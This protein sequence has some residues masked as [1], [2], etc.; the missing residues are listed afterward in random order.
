METIHKL[1]I[2]HVGEAGWEI[3]KFAKWS[4]SPTSISHF[5][6]EDNGKIKTAEKIQPGFLERKGPGRE[7]FQERRDP[8]Q[9]H[10]E[11]GVFRVSARSDFITST[12]HWHLHIIPPPSQWDLCLL[13]P[14][15]HPHLKNIYI[16]QGEAQTFCYIS[17]TGFRSQSSN[18]WRRWRWY[19]TTQR[20]GT[21]GNH[22]YWTGLG[23]LLSGWGAYGLCVCWEKVKKY[24]VTNRQTAREGYG[25][26][27][28]SVLPYIPSPSGS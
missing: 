24:W 27:S 10:R 22:S 8:S 23:Y 16:L 7:L 12:G 1:L 9:A 14:L 21:W 13:L 15:S 20:S 6:K 19:G 18:I 3:L 26:P 17:F 11:G 5:A 2:F 4:Y 25:W 28:I